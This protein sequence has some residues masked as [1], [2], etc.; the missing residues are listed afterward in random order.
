[1]AFEIEKYI[2]EKNFLNRFKN[3]PYLYGLDIPNA[4]KNINALINDTKNRKINIYKGYTIPIKYTGQNADKDLPNDKI[5]N[6]EKVMGTTYGTYTEPNI[7]LH[8][9]LSKRIIPEH[10]L[11]MG[12]E[13]GHAKSRLKLNLKPL[14][15]KI[16]KLR[17]DSK[18]KKADKY[19]KIY[20]KKIEGY[21]KKNQEAI[22]DKNI[23]SYLKQIGM[24]KADRRAHYYIKK[25]IIPRKN[26]RYHSKFGNLKYLKDYIFGF[27]LLPENYHFYKPMTPEW[28]DMMRDYFYGLFYLNFSEQGIEKYKEYLDDRIKGLKD[29]LI[30]QDPNCFKEQKH[31]D[32]GSPERIYWH[33]GELMTLI[34]LRKGL[35]SLHSKISQIGH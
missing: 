24:P 29:W 3:N 25:K 12:H 13:L 26:D 1:M 9:P 16:E 23:P 28:K 18:N 10:K 22:A 8:K 2:G 15:D 11:A 34:D 35:D 32:E 4:N 31:L 5:E 17:T 30:E 21:L 6:P 33:Y 14:E 20:N 19:L 27:S 7:Y